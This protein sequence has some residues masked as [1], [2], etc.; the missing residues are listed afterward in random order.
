MKVLAERPPQI[1]RRRACEALCL[2]RTGTYRRAARPR[3]AVHTLQ[4]RALTP[5]QRQA[6]RAL[7]EQECYLDDSARTVY[8][9]EL[10]E[11]RMHGSISTLYRVLRDD[12][13]TRER[14]AQRPPQRH[15]VPRIRATAPNQ[16]WSWD[17]TK[18][19]TW[20]RGQYLNLY[21]VLD[22]FSRFPVGWMI[23]QKENGAL[24]VHMF[25]QIIEQHRIQPEQLV[26]HQDRGAPMI[27]ESFADLMRSTGITR[28]YSRPRVSND[29]AFSEAQFKT[30][31]YAADYPGRFID[32]DQAR[33]WVDCFVE[34]YRHTPHSGLGLHTPYDVFHGRIE[35]VHEVRQG[36]LDAYWQQHP[37]RFVHRPPKASLPPAEVTINPEDGLTADE[38]LGRPAQAEAQPEPV[39]VPG[40]RMN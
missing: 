11:G 19:P 35:Q 14:R 22:L 16:A 27:A 20:D 24:A 6:V 32:L 8:A 31:K 9:R 5:E 30:L 23:S 4:P 17:I 3:K 25:R 28:S 36:A 12:G 15:T 21:M 37:E 10:S 40:K 38:L 13:Q 18:L 2:S 26:I 33:A 7:F 29:N 39:A 1:S 34:R